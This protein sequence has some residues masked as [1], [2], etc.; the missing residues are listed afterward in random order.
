[1][2]YLTDIFG[3]QPLVSRNLSLLFRAG[4]LDDRREGK[5]IFYSLKKKLPK[6]LSSLMTLLRKELRDNP[7][8][9]SDLKSLGDCTEYQKKTG[10]CNMESFL[11]YMKKKKG[12]D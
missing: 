5:K 4:L 10:K 6:P 3:L 8:H 12:A 7:V 2:R 9:K 1:M 11:A